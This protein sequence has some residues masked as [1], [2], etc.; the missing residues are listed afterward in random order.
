[1]SERASCEPQLDY[2]FFKTQEL[3]STGPVL[4]HTDQQI[5]A[6]MPT[7][8]NCPG[9]GNRLQRELILVSKIATIISRLSHLLGRLLTWLH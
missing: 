5:W 1:M 3:A 4:R 2:S 9:S 6:D 7:S 8:K